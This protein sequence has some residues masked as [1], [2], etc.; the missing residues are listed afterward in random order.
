VKPPDDQVG[1]RERKRADIPRRA[2]RG[3]GRPA[4]F[5]RVIDG[6]HDPGRRKE[7]AVIAARNQGDP[8]FRESGAQKAEGG[9]NDEKITQTAPPDGDY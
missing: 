6:V 1:F 3:Q 8:G 5:V 4:E 2:G 9:K 7:S